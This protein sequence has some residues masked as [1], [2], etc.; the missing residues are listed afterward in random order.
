MSLLAK[1]IWLKIEQTE[2]E[3]SYPEIEMKIHSGP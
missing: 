1:K 3:P 2:S